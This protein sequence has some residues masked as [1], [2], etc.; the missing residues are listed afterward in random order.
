MKIIAASPGFSAPMD[1]AELRGF[2]SLQKLNL[3]LG[4]V[5]V[6]GNP[7]DP[8]AKQFLN[9]VRQGSSVVLEIA[10]VFYSTRDDSKSAH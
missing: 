9:P 10:P 5:D 2:L 8:M 3:H 1:E 6:K 7:E 4:T